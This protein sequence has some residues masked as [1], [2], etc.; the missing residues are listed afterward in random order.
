[1]R[2]RSLL[3]HSGALLR[4]MIIGSRLEAIQRSRPAAYGHTFWLDM[5]SEISRKADQ[6]V[7]ASIGGTSY[8]KDCRTYTLLPF[9]LPL[10]YQCATSRAQER[11]ELH[12]L[13]RTVLFAEA[14]T[15]IRKF[16][17]NNGIDVVHLIDNYGPIQAILSTIKAKKTISH[18]HYEPTFPSYDQLLRL[19]LRP[20]DAI[21]AGSN[22]VAQ[23]LGKLRNPSAVIETIPWGVPSDSFDKATVGEARTRSVL[24][25]GAETTIVLWTGFIRTVVRPAELLFSV[26]VAKRIVRKLPDVVFVFAFKGQQFRH[27]YL[28]F[29]Q[30]GIRVVPLSSRT[31]FLELVRISSLL[32]SPCLNRRATISAPLSWLECMAVGVPVVT[33]DVAG[34][35]EVVAN[36]KNGVILADLEETEGHLCALLR[37]RQRIERLGM[38]AKETVESKFQV[39]RLA[40]AYLNLWGS[41]T[42]R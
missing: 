42:N 1:M 22:M 17:N 9:P 34:A 29:E 25:L 32:F 33:T 20:F 2:A 7:V 36:D 16:V 24:G 15:W 35:E 31:E 40:A 13:F 27:E 12:Y 39:D 23:R 4:I 30:R 5:I 14:C 3:S 19:S 28:N 21:V 18:V 41:L 11:L 38:A 37:D 6:V 26:G 8:Q 10:L